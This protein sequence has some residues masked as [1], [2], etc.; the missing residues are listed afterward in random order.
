[1]LKFRDACKKLNSRTTY[2]PM[3]PLDDNPEFRLGLP[4]GSSMTDPLRPQ[5]RAHQLFHNEE[6]LSYQAMTAH[7]P[8]YHIPFYSYLQIRHFLQN[9]KPNT[10]WYREF[11]PFEYICNSKEPQRH[12]IS[13]VYALLFSTHK[14]KDDKLVRQWESDLQLDL[15]EEEWG[16]IYSHI[17]KGSINVFT[18][19]Q[20]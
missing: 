13:T 6:L 20:I 16:H 11:T 15:N 3:T 5:L 18:R 2:G 10:L 1:M 14:I 4:L 17:H 8:D 9:S 12:L 19:K 7:F